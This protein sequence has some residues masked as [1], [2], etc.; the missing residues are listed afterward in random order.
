MLPP[1]NPDE[2]SVEAIPSA[3][4]LPGTKPKAEQIKSGAN[5]YP[6]EKEGDSIASKS[7]NSGERCG[8]DARPRPEP[9]MIV[10]WDEPEDQDP[11]K[12]MNWPLKE[13]WA[14]ILTIAVISFLV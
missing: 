2:S 14:N 4:N 5:T 1:P 11:Q 9:E 13:K 6:Y 8:R 3:N 12:P 7:L 10:W